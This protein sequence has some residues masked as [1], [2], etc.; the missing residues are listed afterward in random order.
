[1]LGTGGVSLI[2]LVLARAAGALT[3]ITSSLDEKLDFVKE[4]YGVDHVIN[5][6]KTP[7]WGKEALH[8][9]DG[10]GVDFVFENGG[11]AKSRMYHKR[12]HCCSDWILIQ[13]FPGEYA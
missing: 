8:L 7:V 5:Y 13:G 2:G 3:I 11:Q 9:T 4:K 1:V 6:K 10:R 12:R